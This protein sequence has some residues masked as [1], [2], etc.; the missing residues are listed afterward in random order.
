MVVGP[1]PIIGNEQVLVPLAAR[2]GL[3]P[4]QA[5][6]RLGG[7]DERQVRVLLALGHVRLRARDVLRAIRVLDEMDGTPEEEERPVGLEALRDG[8]AVP[9]LDDAVGGGGRLDE[10]LLEPLLDSLERGG[11]AAPSFLPRGA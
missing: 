2:P 5:L 7:G 11:E 1:L 8:A 6:E 4:A 3:D 10:P 9:E